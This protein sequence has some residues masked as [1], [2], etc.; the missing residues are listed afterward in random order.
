MSTIYT[1]S[2]NQQVTLVCSDDAASVAQ[3][4]HEQMLRTLHF[5]LV[6][7]ADKQQREDEKRRKNLERIERNRT[8]LLRNKAKNQGLPPARPRGTI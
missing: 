3:A 1:F 8:K 2:N 6:V 4:I 5:G 7:H